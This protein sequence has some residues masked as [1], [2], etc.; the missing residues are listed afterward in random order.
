MSWKRRL[1]PCWIAVPVLVIALA[2]CDSGEVTGDGKPELIP[3]RATIRSCARD[4]SSDLVVDIVLRGEGVL[5]GYSID[6]TSVNLFGVT[7]Q[8]PDGA[9]RELHYVVEIDTTSPTSTLTLHLTTAE[10]PNAIRVGHLTFA[11]LGS[12]TITAPSIAALTDKPMSVG[13]VEAIVR[14]TK[15]R[16]G[17]IVIGLTLSPA[18]LGGSLI[19]MGLHNPRMEIA[20][21][22]F[23]DE[24][25]SRSRPLGTQVAQAVA[26][27]GEDLG[28]ITPQ[29]GPARLTAEG[30]TLQNTGE[31]RL[32]LPAGC[33]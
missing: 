23:R 20:G 28:R 9:E 6:T 30:V 29:S 12:E 3:V 13:P 8:Y 16:S 32:L 11:A 25:L 17:S 22:T 5:S 15:I 21:Q 26:L 10:V 2:S 7:G 4:V 1:K 19:V 31:L 18:G 33:E 27:V 24:G 14:T